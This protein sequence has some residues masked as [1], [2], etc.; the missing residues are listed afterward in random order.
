M[1]EGRRVPD[2]VLEQYALGELP[3]SERSSLESALEEDPRLR[4]RL[5]ALRRSDEAILAAQPPA[6][7]AASIRRRALALE[8]RGS[9]RAAPRRLPYFAISAAAVALL[10]VGVVAIKGSLFP[11]A[12]D[13]TRLKGGTA[14]LS[15]FR[16]T[17]LGAEELREGSP[18]QAGDLLQIR[19]AAEGSRY[20]ALFSIDG[21]GAVSFHLPPGYR[22]GAAAAPALDP[23]GAALGSAYELDDA[24]LFERF[25]MV[26]SPSAFDLGAVWAVAL[27]L[28]AKGRDAVGPRSTKDLSWSELTIIKKEASR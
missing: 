10:L 23:R 5:E 17:S 28:A 12:G 15:V 2:L 4:E 13:I 7:V 26:S 27:E 1:S 16:R 25:Y 6:Q 22:G 24:P 3:P 21:R 19:Y 11:S 9:E 18:A 14:L 20:G 8:P